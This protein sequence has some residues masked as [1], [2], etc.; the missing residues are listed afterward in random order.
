[1]NRKQNLSSAKCSVAMFVAI[2]ILAGSV[3]AVGQTYRTVYRFKDG[4]D[5]VG[6]GGLIFDKAGNLYGTTAGGGGGQDG[7]CG[8]T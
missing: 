5:G 7:A 3:L 4:N 1:M 6:P 2:L 8:D